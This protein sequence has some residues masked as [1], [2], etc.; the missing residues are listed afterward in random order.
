MRSVTSQKPTASQ[1]ASVI[2]PSNEC[3]SASCH[4]NPPHVV[5]I[6]D[7]TNTSMGPPP[8]PLPHGYTVGPDVAIPTSW[9]GSAASPIPSRLMGP[10]GY[11][12]H[13]RLYLTEHQRWFKLS[14]ATPGGAMAE[15]ISLEISATHKV[16]GHKKARGTLIGGKKDIDT[17]ID[18]PSL[19]NF[20]V[21]SM[22]LLCENLKWV[23]LATH[24]PSILY[25]YSQCLQPARKG[26]AKAPIFKMKQSSLMVVVPE[27]QWTEFEDWQEVNEMA[28]EH[29]SR[30][31]KGK[32]KADPLFL[33]DSA[34]SLTY[35]YSTDPPFDPT[36]PPFG[37]ADP[38]ESLA[39]TYST[40]LPFNSGD[41]PFD[42]ESTPNISSAATTVPVLSTLSAAATVPVPVTTTGAAMSS[43]AATVSLTK[44]THEHAISSTSSP[45]R[46]HNTPC[47]PLPVLCSPD[48]NNLK[49]ALKIGG[50]ADLD[51]Q[52]GTSFFADVCVQHTHLDVSV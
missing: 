32:G 30:H 12:A 2:H 47:N 17:Q 16:A 44:Q 38:A 46:K 8:V 43:A 24:L 7:W 3:Q 21:L 11:S 19:I 1:P 25:F 33:A 50:G 40:D 29:S 5:A 14:Y 22:N 6:P 45:P 18:A 34:E 10:I 52:Q 37:S 39:Y 13:H 35:T 26:P 41:P 31:A 27:V 42:S 36:G 9:Q 23:D 15:T 4:C 20:H 51:M 28:I 49:I 48:R